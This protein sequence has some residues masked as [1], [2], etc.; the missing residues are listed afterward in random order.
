[1][2]IFDSAI[3]G[4]VTFGSVTFGSVTFGSVTFGS[5]TFGSVTFGDVANRRRFAASPTKPVK[6]ISDSRQAQTKL[7]YLG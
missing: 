2:T 4:S 3:F 7:R 5:V 6:G 1:L